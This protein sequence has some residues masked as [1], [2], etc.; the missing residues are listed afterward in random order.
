MSDAD[1]NVDAMQGD[2]ALAAIGPR[3]R[4]AQWIAHDHYWVLT[5]TV[6]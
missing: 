2:Q 5:Y 6:H 3:A 1:V 4:Q